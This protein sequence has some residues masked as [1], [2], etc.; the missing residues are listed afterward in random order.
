MSQQP[1]DNEQWLTYGDCRKCRRAK[2][3]Q[4]PCTRCNRRRRAKM[5]AAVAETIDRFTGGAMRHLINSKYV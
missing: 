2:Y 3:C 5:Q 1:D 4:K